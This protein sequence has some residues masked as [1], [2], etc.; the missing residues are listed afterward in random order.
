LRAIRCY[1]NAGFKVDGKRAILQSG[2][3]LSKFNILK[4]HKIMDINA[5]W[6]AVLQQDAKTMRTFFKDTAYINWH[7]TNEHFTVEEYIRANCEYPGEWDGIVERT[8]HIGNLI[9]TV[10]NVFTVSRDLSFHV[11]SFMNIEDDKIISLD[12]YWGDDGLAPQWRLDKK[13]GTS[14]I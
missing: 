9:I 1:Q 13:I 8:E 4:G 7:C 12:E 14:I 11:V 6:N 10:V 5:F 3:D 2:K